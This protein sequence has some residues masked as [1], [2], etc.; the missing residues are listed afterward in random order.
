MAITRGDVGLLF[1]IAGFLLGGIALFHSFKAA[2]NVDGFT[3]TVEQDGVTLEQL[4][5]DTHAL[6]GE[7]AEANKRIS[8][9]RKEFM[10]HVNDFETLRRRVD[11]LEKR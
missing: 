1:G 9:Q 2:A 10:D 3:S 8:S 7:G 4:V 5:E 6:K 11:A